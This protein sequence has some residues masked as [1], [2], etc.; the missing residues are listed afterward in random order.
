MCVYILSMFEQKLLALQPKIF[1][2]DQ[3]DIEQ[4]ITVLTHFY[5]VLDCC[6]G[7]S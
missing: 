2:I 7:Q 3:N 1:N 4:Y 6:K 5:T